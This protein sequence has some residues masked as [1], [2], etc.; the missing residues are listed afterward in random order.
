MRLQADLAKAQRIIDVQRQL[1]A[2]L[3]QLATGGA[4]PTGCGPT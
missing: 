4:E 3:A 1:S 2:L